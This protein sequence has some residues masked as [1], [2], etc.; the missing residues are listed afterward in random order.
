ME[1]AG[2]ARAGGDLDGLFHGVL[3]E[4][5][6][7]E[8]DLEGLAHSYFHAVERID[9][10]IRFVGAGNSAERVRGAGFAPGTVSNHIGVAVVGIE[11]QRPG[12]GPAAFVRAERTF[13]RL[14]GSAGQ[15]H[16][17][18]LAVAHLE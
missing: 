7:T 2:L 6:L 10:G 5:R 17:L 12:R 14:A 11:F 8:D 15:G 18:N 3:V 13:D 9:G 1:G 4:Y 16:P